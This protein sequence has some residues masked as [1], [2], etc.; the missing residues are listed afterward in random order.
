M[1]NNTEDSS[2]DRHHAS[3]LKILENGP[4]APRCP[5][6][7]GPLSTVADADAPTGAAMVCTTCGQRRGMEVTMLRTL[8]S[9]QQTRF[10]Q[11]L[12]T[13]TE[14]PSLADT[15]EIPRLQPQP[16]PPPQ[17]ENTA[18]E[19]LGKITSETTRDD[20]TAGDETSFDFPTQPGQPARGRQPDGTIRTTGWLQ[21]G[22]WPISSGL[23]AA[24]AGAA[25]G[26]ALIDLYTWLP[27]IL[28][29]T[30][31]ATW[32]AAIRWVRPASAATNLELVYADE[33]EPDDAIRI[34]GPIGPVGIVDQITP[35]NSQQVLIRFTGGTQRFLPAD[36]RCH[37]VKLRN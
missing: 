20:L 15:I 8:L 12:A 11:P 37:L 28:A 10:D 1:M 23:W 36:T 22:R 31:Y 24:L 14:N 35:A 19:P 4:Y 16:P 13:P 6:G 32:F 26:L 5:D 18:R 25:L 29:T 2:T 7:H 34:H 9:P 27:L 17:P 33:L 30:A 3:A 21:L